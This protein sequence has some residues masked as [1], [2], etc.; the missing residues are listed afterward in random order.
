M[1]D[2][3]VK[4]D[5]M[6]NRAIGIFDSGIG[7]LTVVKEILKTLPDESLIYLGD[8]ARVPYGI[9]DRV[10]ITK[11][12]LELAQF[13]LERKVKALIIACNTISATC[14]KE[15]Q[16]KSPV[17]VLGVIEPTVKEAVRQSKNKII[18]AIGT[19]ATIGSGIYEEKI[20][21]LDPDIQVLSK[22]CPL[23][24]PLAEEGEIN[25]PATKIIAREYLEKLTEEGIDTLVLGCT[26]YPLLAAVIREILGEGVSLVDSAKPTALELKELLTQ[27]NLLN[28]NC[29]PTYQ[30]YVTDAPA[31]AQEIAEQFFHGP[32][33]CRLEKINLENHSTR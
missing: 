20:H 19:R 11:F 10:V 6:T 15:I 18:G 25:S 8:T 26:H 16:E 3:S 29:P 31:R 2:F 33:P 23:F 24:V 7:G 12:S 1:D 5:Q 28:T 32:L 22:A 4:I 30:F 17:P 9:R 21:L 27:Q 14:L 13:L